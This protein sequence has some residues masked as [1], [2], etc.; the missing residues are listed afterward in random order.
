MSRNKYLSNVWILL[1]GN[2]LLPVFNFFP[3]GEFILMFVK[4]TLHRQ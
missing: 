1:L 3:E 2:G 4:I